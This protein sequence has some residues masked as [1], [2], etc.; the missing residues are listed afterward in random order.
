MAIGGAINYGSAYLLMLHSSKRGWAP[1]FAV[2]VGCGAGMMVNY[3]SMRW[4][5]FRR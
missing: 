4:Y 3:A 5:V 2:A 1:Q